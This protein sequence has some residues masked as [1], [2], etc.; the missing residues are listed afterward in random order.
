MLV[1]LKNWVEFPEANH[2]RHTG[3]VY[4]ADTVRREPRQHDFENKEH[5][6]QAGIKSAFI[7]VS[8]GEKVFLQFART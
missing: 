1:A 2:A 7:T 8:S 4:N 3:W 5:F 6:S